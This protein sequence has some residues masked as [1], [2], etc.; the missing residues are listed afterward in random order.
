VDILYQVSPTSIPILQANP[1]IDILQ[2]DMGFW[3]GFE[4]LT[5]EPPFDDVRVR[6]AL[7][8]AT[9]REAI[10]QVFALGDGY[11]G[12]DHPINPANPYLG[13]H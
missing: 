6:K 11:L 13:W 8:L 2:S 1:N 12:N 9:D 10:R 3:F 4:M 7:K 5:F